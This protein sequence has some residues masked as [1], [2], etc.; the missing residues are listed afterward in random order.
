ML[1]GVALLIQFGQITPPLKKAVRT[2]FHVNWRCHSE[3]Q[4]KEL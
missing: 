4:I 3:P 1:Y 2:I